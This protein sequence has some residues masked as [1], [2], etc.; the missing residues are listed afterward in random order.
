MQQV[1]PRPS[2]G[3]L[4]QVTAS[5]TSKPTIRRSNQPVPKPAT[6]N[7]SSSRPGQTR[8]N[9]ISDQSRQPQSHQPINQT[10]SL[11]Q[12]FVTESAS[13]RSCTGKVII[14]YRGDGDIEERVGNGGGCGDA[15]EN[16][17]ES[18]KFA[19]KIWIGEDELEGSE[20]GDKWESRKRQAQKAD[21]K[22]GEIVGVVSEPFHELDEHATALRNRFLCFRHEPRN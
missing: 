5:T 21:Q 20:D 22:V 11:Q 17:E 19:G 6:G 13:P 2:Q 15:G 9:Q 18:E 16:E 12:S 4:C 1:P 14:A 7:K 3:Q 8:P 10:Q